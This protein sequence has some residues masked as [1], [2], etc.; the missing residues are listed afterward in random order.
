MTIQIVRAPITL[1]ELRSLAREQFGDMVKAMVE[2]GQEIM[3][4]GG[5]LQA[6]QEAILLDQALVRPMSEPG[7]TDVERVELASGARVHRLAAD[8]WLPR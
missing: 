5:E 7:A 3:A 8:G 2:V 6:D 1:A 4:I